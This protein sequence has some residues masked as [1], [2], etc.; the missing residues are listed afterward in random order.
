[1]GHHVSL[2]GSWICVADLSLARSPAAADQTPCMDLVDH[3][4]FSGTA[5]GSC[6][7]AWA[8]P[9]AAVL[10]APVPSLLPRRSQP[11]LADLASCLDPG[12]ASSLQTQLIVTRL[13][14]TPA[15]APELPDS[16]QALPKPAATLSCRFPCPWVKLGAPWLEERQSE[17]IIFPFIS[18]EI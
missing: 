10:L 2:D 5:D 18:V 15:A 14:L 11:C 13:G 8:V 3:L 1:M 4:T 12:L 7:L 9:R 16:H 6:F 17:P